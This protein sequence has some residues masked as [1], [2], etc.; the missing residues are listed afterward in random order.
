MQCTHDLE[1][2]VTGVIHVLRTSEDKTF[3]QA[4]LELLTLFAN[5]AAI[6]VENTRLL[7]QSKLE[8]AERKQAE[9][10]LHKSEE[11]FRTILDNILEDDSCMRWT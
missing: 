9:N 8:L 2:Q 1:N 11:R 4:D 6:A 10:E 7:Q 3:T 5:H